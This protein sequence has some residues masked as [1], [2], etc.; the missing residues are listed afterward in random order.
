MSNKTLSIAAVFLILSVAAG[1]C[2][3]AVFDKAGTM[4]ETKAGTQAGEAV[5]SDIH[6]ISLEELKNSIKG[7][8]GDICADYQDYSDSLEDMKDIAVL[9]VRASVTGQLQYSDMSVQSTLAVSETWKGDTFNQIRVYQFG[10]IGGE[11]VLSPD[12][13]YILFLGKQTDGEKDTFFINGGEQGI[14]IIDNGIINP[15]DSVIKKDLKK[16][17]KEMG[18]TFSLEFFEESIKE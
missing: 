6:T 16:I 10:T 3:N 1:F 5:S 15:I 14:I 18:A 9:I 11:K 2:L 7:F 17:E 13:E 12:K 4:A 8:K